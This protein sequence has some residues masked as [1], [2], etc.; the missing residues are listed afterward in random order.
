M[1]PFRYL[2]LLLLTSFACIGVAHAQESRADS[3]RQAREQKQEALQPYDANALETAL[4]AVERGGVP[5][6]TRDGI[7][8]KLGSLTTGSGFAYGTGYRTS[9]LFRREG[10]LDVW[11]GTSAKGYWAAE[12]RAL[13]PHLADGRLLLEGYA[14][15]HEYPRGGLLRP[16]ARLA[17]A[18]PDRLQPDWPTPSAGARAFAPRGS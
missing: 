5:L 18:Q 9:R 2:S 4:R 3:L 17:P 13:F 11:A 8:L 7:Y 16:R 10:K 6:I 1:N 15:R 14:R 12:A